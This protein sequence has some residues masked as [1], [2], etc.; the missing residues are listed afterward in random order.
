[1]KA[2]ETI[3]LTKVY[4]NG[5]RALREVSITIPKG[6]TASLVGPN[7]AGKTTLI[8]ILSTQLLPTKG[9]ARILGLD[10]VNEAKEV[11][12]RISVVP[13]EAMPFSELTPWEHVY[14]Y[15]VA[16]GY[17]FSDARRQCELI[18]KDL[19]LWSIRNIPSIKLSGGLKRRILVAMALA[20]NADVVLLDEPS[21]GLD[22]LARGKMW[23]HILRLSKNDNRTF[24]IT[25]HYMEEAETLAQQVIII[26]NGKVL[27]NGNP[28]E[29]KKKVVP[30]DVKI[31]LKHLSKHEVKD[32]ISAFKDEGLLAIKHGGRILIYPRARSLVEDII[33][34]AL[35]KGEYEVSVQ[36]VTLEDVFLLLISGHNSSPHGE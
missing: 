35:A 7:G 14:Y 31:I 26:N 30:S 20:V 34:E 36:P 1:M 9:Q 29:L 10:V 24:L 25:T 13:Q 8:K 15:L 12:K 32:I 28:M 17:S 23:D 27:A 16:R 6:I 11:R 5:V 21:I 33:K 2:I 22:P 19:D 3:E 18:L 4:S